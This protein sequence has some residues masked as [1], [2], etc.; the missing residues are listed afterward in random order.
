[1]REEDKQRAKNAMYT[2]LQNG[3]EGRTQT[4]Y[5]QSSKNTEGPVNRDQRKYNNE[6]G[7]LPG[8]RP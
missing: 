1:M 6:L 5:T 8:D 7:L 4:Q 2:K 3:C